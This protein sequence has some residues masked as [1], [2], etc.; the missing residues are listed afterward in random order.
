[1]TYACLNCQDERWVCEN[2]PHRPWGVSEAA[3]GCS[4]GAGNPCELCNPC[5]RDNPPVMPPGAVE[6]C[7]NDLPRGH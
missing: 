2:H 1:V 6:I 7:S 3:G 5:D 4:C